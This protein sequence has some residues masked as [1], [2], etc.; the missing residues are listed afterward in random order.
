M[1][2]ISVVMLTVWFPLKAYKGVTFSLF[3]DLVL[4]PTKLIPMNLIFRNS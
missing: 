3:S 1:C 4:L 2:D